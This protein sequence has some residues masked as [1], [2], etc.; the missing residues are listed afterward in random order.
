MKSAMSFPQFEAELN[1]D[2]CDPYT[3]ADLTLT[4]KLGFRQINPAVGSTVAGYHDLGDPTLPVRKIVPWTIGSWNLWKKNFVDTATRFWDGKFWLSNNFPLYEYE[5]NPLGFWAPQAS[6]SAGLRPWD[7]KSWLPGDFSMADAGRTNT[8]YRPNIW[9]RLKIVDR[10][11]SFGGHHHVIDV[12]RLHKDEPFF[13]SHAKLYDQRDINSAT[14]GID[15][16]GQ[17]I[18]QRTHVHEIGHLLGLGHVDIGKPHCP[19]GGNTNANLCYGVADNDQYS[20]MGRGMQ[21]RPEHAMPWRR[22][23]VALSGKGNALTATDWEVRMQKLY[24][25]LPGEAA[26]NAMLTHRPNRK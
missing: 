16:K 14:T 19:P 10:D 4:L 2:H 5:K 18:V 24:P 17:K 23:M 20:V 6:T 25:R 12:I 3:N 15:S 7:S 9:C 22:A 26:A 1:T 21:L 8:R 13:R 11:I